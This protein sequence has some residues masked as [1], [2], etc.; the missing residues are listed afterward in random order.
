MQL[1]TIRS[2]DAH[3]RKRVPVLDSEMSFVDVRTG[4]PIVFLHGN[5]DSSYLWRNVIRHVV[6][7][8]RCCRSSFALLTGSSVNGM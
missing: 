5:A 4:D 6:D 2:D 1:T 3:P 7:C 8:G